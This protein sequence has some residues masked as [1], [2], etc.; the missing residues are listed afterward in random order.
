[1]TINYMLITLSFFVPIVRLGFL[2]LNTRE[3]INPRLFIMEWISSGI[4]ACLVQFLA[5]DIPY[6]SKHQTTITIITA[7]FAKKIFI[8]ADQNIKPIMAELITKLFTKK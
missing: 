4:M 3:K 2:S 7:L 5:I 1:M 8:F 6:I